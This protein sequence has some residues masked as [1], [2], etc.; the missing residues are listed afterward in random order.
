[1]FP[2]PPNSPIH[3]CHMSD[4]VCD[5]SNCAQQ[6]VSR[7]FSCGLKLRFDDIL[8]HLLSSY[9]FSQN[10]TMSNIVESS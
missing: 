4:R 7:R 10:C 3:T 5:V 8:F 6:Y 1:M 2:H 9:S